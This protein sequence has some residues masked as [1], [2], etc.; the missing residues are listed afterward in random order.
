MIQPQTLLQR[1]ANDY[2]TVRKNSFT[3]TNVPRNVAGLNEKNQ[4]SENALTM[5][6]TKTQ[7]SV[8]ESAG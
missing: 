6:Q 5:A 4:T 8:A 3:M 2:A 1:L 7:Y